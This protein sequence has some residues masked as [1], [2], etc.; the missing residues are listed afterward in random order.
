ML[1][2]DDDDANADDDCTSLPSFLVNNDD[3]DIEGESVIS[4]SRF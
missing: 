4:G 2:D 3:A 1:D